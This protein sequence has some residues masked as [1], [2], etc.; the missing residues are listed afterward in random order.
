VQVT[1]NR[2]RLSLQ[3]IETDTD[4]HLWAETFEDELTDVIQIQA[5]VADETVQ[6]LD[7]LEQVFADPVG[8]GEFADA[9]RVAIDSSWKDFRDDPRFKGN[10]A[11]Y[12]PKD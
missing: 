12:R 3:L 7:L 11:K 10:V 6:A 1:A 8:G 9:A 2:V 4:A 5:A